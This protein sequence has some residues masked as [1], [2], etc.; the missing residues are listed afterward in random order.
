[1]ISRGEVASS[2][3]LLTPHTAAM[4]RI[5][6]MASRRRPPAGR[7]FHRPIVGDT[8]VLKQRVAAH[9]WRLG[10]PPRSTASMYL[11]IRG[12]ASDPRPLYVRIP[13]VAAVIP[14]VV[15]D[16]PRRCL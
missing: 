6:R 11:T 5:S 8:E 4:R 2:P 1:M 12:D 10:M 16:D 3:R 13:C 9:S 14:A 7:T 15:P